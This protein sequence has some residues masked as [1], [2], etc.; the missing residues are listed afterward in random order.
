MTETNTGRYRSKTL[1]ARHKRASAASS[2][3]GMNSTENAISPGWTAV[4]RS[5]IDP[6]SCSS[7]T[8]PSRRAGWLSPVQDRWDYSRF[9]P[10][11]SGT[12][13]PHRERTPR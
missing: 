3:G 10:R 5:A 7:A 6:G 11:T 9:T 12:E 1:A 4:S 13:L 2:R 8:G